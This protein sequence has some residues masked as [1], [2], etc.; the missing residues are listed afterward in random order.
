MPALVGKPPRKY[1]S[2]SP[3]PCDFVTERVFL[4]R[5]AEARALGRR[6]AFRGQ[7]RNRFIRS[8]MAG[9]LDGTYGSTSLITGL[10]SRSRLRSDSGGRCQLRSINFNT[11][12]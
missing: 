12:T 6:V 2:S 7:N 1:W 8:P 5:K 4:R 11:D 3:P 9:R 10:G